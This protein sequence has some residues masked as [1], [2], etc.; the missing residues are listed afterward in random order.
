MA[1]KNISFWLDLLHVGK[2]SDQRVRLWNG[3]LGWKLP[4]SVKGKFDST[5]GWPQL[6]VD[7]PDGDCP[8]LTDEEKETIDDLADTHGGHPAFES[9]YMDFSGHRF[10]HHS[11]FS[12]LT[13]VLSK[14]DNVQFEDTVTFDK[15]RYYGQTFFDGAKFNGPAHFH[16]TSFDAPVSFDG[17]EF[18]HSATF[19]GVQ[20]KGG[21]SFRDVVYR[22]PVMFNDSRFEERYYS[23]GIGTHILADFT[24]AKFMSRAS[25]REV[26]FG[27][28]ESSY[29]RRLWPER[30]ADF[31]NARFMAT[32]DFRRAA[33]AGPPAF[34]HTSLHEDTDFSGIDWKKAET[35]HVDI[36]YA[37]RAWERLELI[38][39]RIE[40]PLERHRFFRL[41]MRARRRT[42]GRFLRL[43]NWLFDIIAGYGW[44]IGRAFTWWIGHWTVS[45]LFLFA[46][47]CPTAATVDWWELALSALATGFA[48]AHPF[49]LLATPEGH[50]KSVRELLEVNN[51]WNL[52]TPIGIWEAVLGPIFLFFLALTL[53]NRFR[54]A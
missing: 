39:S 53:R 1:N 30:R 50:L 38:M 23:A 44:S 3:Y 27:N 46:N 29:S 32:T 4:S 48:N 49:L 33:F 6:I 18:E 34:F 41:K 40:K 7:A 22:A 15:T 47:S 25:F 51:T 8:E 54:L 5:G 9:D 12:G 19:I 28:D 35:E 37:I 2:D 17:S 31:T 43:L 21:A 45:A 26:L 10:A 14:F 13:L 16:R 36:E 20:F 42:D 11:D 52:L 24:N